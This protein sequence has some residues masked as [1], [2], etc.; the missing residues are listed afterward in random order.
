MITISCYLYGMNSK[1][2]FF[3]IF[4]MCKFHFSG[5]AQVDFSQQIAEGRENTL[6]EH[7]KPYVILISVDG[8]R[9]DYATKFEAKNLQQ[10]AIKGVQAEWMIPSFP[11]LTFPNHYSM[12]T[13]LY[14]AHHGVVANSFYDY[15]MK[16]TYGIRNRDAVENALWYGGTPLWVLA[17]KQGM[18]AASYFWVG[19][20]APIQDTYP[21]YYFR[22]TEQTPIKER[23][24]TVVDWLSLPINKRPHLITFYLPE[25]DLAGHKF[26]A[27]STEVEKAVHF[28]DSVIEELTVAVAKTK[29][30]V[31]FIVVSDHGMANI[32]QHETLTIPSAIDTVDFHIVSS[33]TM[34]HLYS[35][36]KGSLKKTY[37]DIKNI[38]GRYDVYL[39]TKL[40]KKLNYRTSDDYFNR[41]GDVVLVAKQPFVFHCLTG[42]V[43]NP[44]A[45]G[46]DARVYKNMMAIFMAWG[47]NI[48]EGEKIKPFSNVNVYPLVAKILGLTITE[49][50]D[51]DKKFY[52]KVIH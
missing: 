16:E 18:L 19:S 47:P 32:N 1:F 13:G 12:V 43:P 4:L 42:R 49:K 20:E 9:Y 5:F 30:P 14:P 21:S 24:K 37:Q 11:T 44:G 35:K 36:N 25:V 41:L 22:Y 52:K 39:K 26:G 29:L 7:D 51:G 2:S 31:N 6:L 23:L 48:K 8:F 17:E 15:E 50:I 33:G 40:P 38:D 10:L 28:V 34:V 45:H 27:E 3:I 46:Y